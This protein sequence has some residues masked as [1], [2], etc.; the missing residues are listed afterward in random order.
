MQAST[1]MGCT[2]QRQAGRSRLLAVSAALIMALAALLS[3]LA[4]SSSMESANAG[5]QKELPYTFFC[6]H[7]R[8][9]GGPNNTSG[10]RYQSNGK[11]SAKAPDGSKVI[12]T[13]KGGW[14]PTTDTA[15]GG[16]HYTIKGSS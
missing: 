16:G 5:V 2:P 7:Y 11:P 10:V 14:K 13:G 3:T 12:L 4:L 1:N 15:K 6:T 8:L 9:L